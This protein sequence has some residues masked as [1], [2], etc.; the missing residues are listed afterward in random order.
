MWSVPIDY[1]ILRLIWWFF[2]GLLLIGFAIMDGFD[3]G[4]GILL[5][6]VARNDLERRVV[7]NSIGP[8]WEG[9]QVWLI[10][11]AGAIFAAFPPIYAAAFSGFYVAMFLVLLSLILRPVGFDFR[12]KVASPVWRN[13][14]DGA[15]FIAGFVPALVFGVALGNLLQGVPFVLD[16]DLRSSYEGTF[17][18]LL[19]PFALVAGLLSVSMLVMHGGTFLV[20]KTEGPIAARAA[21]AIQGGAVTTI[22]L[23]AAAGV[24]ITFGIDGYT[25]TSQIDPSGPSDPLRKEVAIQAGAWFENYGRYPW[26]IA[27]PVLGFLGAAGAFVLTRGGHVVGAFVS[28]ALALFGIISTAGVSMFPFLMPSSTD[29]SSS[30]TVW[31]A[32]SS[33]MTLYIMLIATVIFLPLIIVYTSFVFRILRGKVSAEYVENNS[34]SLY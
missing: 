28:S 2:L 3:L 9:N 25:I 15:L 32:T 14:W 4:I 18:G 23:F 31:D 26:M 8:V 7:I 27:A 13:A 5:P 12:N 17:F 6:F 21:A 11:G 29:P 20:L 16:T 22:V 34:K 1:E 30:L 24:W 19:N 33:Q 10:L